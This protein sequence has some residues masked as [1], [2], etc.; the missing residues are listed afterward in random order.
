MRA[1]LF[2]VLTVTALFLSHTMGLSNRKIAAPDFTLMDIDGNKV[3]LHDFKGKVVYLDIWAS[4]CPPCLAQMAPAKK[5]K[6]QFHDNKDIVFLYVSIDKDEQRWK[7][8]VK[9]KDIK[10]IHLLSKGGEEEGIVQKYDV[11]AIPKFVLID[12]QGNIA[13][14]DA[15]WPSDSELKD[16]IEKLLAK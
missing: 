1:F 12:K 16:D 13:D 14:G 15:K 9:K 11:P 5:L 2:S 4:W 8:M 10:G 6:E 3:S 7:D